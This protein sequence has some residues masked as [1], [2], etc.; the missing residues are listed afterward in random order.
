VSDSNSKVRWSDAEKRLIVCNAAD[1][2]AARPDLAGLPL[3]RQ[4]VKMLPASRRRDVGTLSRVEWFEPALRDEVRRRCDNKPPEPVTV[5]V[6]PDD[7]FLPVLR[8]TNARATSLQAGV[9]ALLPVARDTNDRIQVLERQCVVRD[10]LLA[11]IA[12]S[13]D[14]MKETLVAAALLLQMLH[15]ETRDMNQKFG[16]PVPIAGQQLGRTAPNLARTPAL[17]RRTGRREIAGVSFGDEY[18]EMEA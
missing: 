7:P 18:G 14:T 8:D 6:A 4:A 3:L 9:E 12:C 2:Q 13:I 1:I 17:R 5:V 15:G 10:E 11:R 16:R